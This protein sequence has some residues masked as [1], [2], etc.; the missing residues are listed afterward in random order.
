MGL[1]DTVKVLGYL[2]YDHLPYLYTLARLLVYPSLFE[3]FGIPLIEAM[4]LGCPVACS[5]VT[6]I[7]EVIGDAGVTFDPA[8]VEDIA[9]KVSGLWNDESLRRDLR[10]KGL[11]RVRVFTWENTARETIKVYKK[12]ADKR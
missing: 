9:E 5:N 3:G 1:E 2:P 7:P 11:E 6:S 8:S 10:I 12:A 4:A